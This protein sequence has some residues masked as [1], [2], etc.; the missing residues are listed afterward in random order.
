MM[1]ENALQRQ[2]TLFILTIK[3]DVAIPLTGVGVGWRPAH[4]FPQLQAAPWGRPSG[5]MLHTSA[6]LSP[7]LLSPSADPR[8]F[9]RWSPLA[10][11]LDPRAMVHSFCCFSEHLKATVLSGIPRLIAM[12]N[13]ILQTEDNFSKKKTHAVR[14]HNHK[15]TGFRKKQAFLALVV[16]VLPTQCSL[17]LVQLPGC[18]LVLARNQRVRVLRKFF[19]MEKNWIR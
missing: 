5:S 14:N 17:A 7:P 12:L 6:S 11:S 3:P 19:E 2:G 4:S 18:L 13:W 9:S 15:H 8:V 10:R 1:E 16:S